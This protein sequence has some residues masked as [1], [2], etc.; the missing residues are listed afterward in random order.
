MAEEVLAVLN[1]PEVVAQKAK[2]TLEYAR[3]ADIELPEVPKKI[4]RSLARGREIPEFVIEGVRFA[5]K[6]RGRYGRANPR[7]IFYTLVNKGLIGKTKRE[8]DNLINWLTALRLINVVPFDWIHDAGRIISGGDYSFV[9]PEK[10]L[11][12]QLKSLED[13]WKYYSL[14]HWY[15]QPYYV[16]VWC[17]KL[18]LSDFINNALRDLNVKIRYIRGYAPWALVYKAAEEFKSIK[19]REI[20]ILHLGDF[21]PSGEDIVRRAVESLKYFGFKITYRKVAVT[22]EQIAEFN[23][24][25]KPEGAKAKETIERAL[26]D[27]RYKWFVERYGRLFVVELD[28]LFTEEHI[29]RTFK[30]IREAVLEYFDRSIAEK[31]RAE[32]ERLKL[33]IK[34]RIEEIMARV[35]GEAPKE[36]AIERIMEVKERRGKVK[37]KGREYA[38]R[39]GY[40]QLT[41]PVDYIGKKVRVCVDLVD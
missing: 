9:E 8:L 14:P 38:K 18:G 11:E 13:A 2:E 3:K 31:V 35:K 16:E 15:R 40:L 12:L 22:L 5:A 20:V 41:L 29:D 21:D 27:P 30:M 4:I 25:E 32:E 10:Y 23:L 6:V 19:D 36:H 7:T 26:R 39:E 28:T 24:P 37:V 17:E 34:A 33:K 1:N